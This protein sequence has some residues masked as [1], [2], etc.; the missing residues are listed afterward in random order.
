MKQDNLFDELLDDDGEEKLP[1]DNND[2][3]LYESIYNDENGETKEEP[4]KEPDKEENESELFKFEESE[5]I[6]KILE[7]KGINPHEIL[8]E[9]ENGE[10]VKVNFYELDPEEQ[11]NLLHYNPSQY[12]LD[13]KEVEAI[14]FF[15]ENDISLEDYTEYVKQTAIEEYTKTSSSYDIDSYS[16]EEVY[17]ALLKDQFP[18]LT[19]EEIGMEI[20]KEKTNT[21]LFEKKVSQIREYYKVQADDIKQQEAEESNQKEQLELDETKKQ[22]ANAAVSTEELMGFEIDDNDRREAFKFI[23]DKSVNGKSAF[24]KLLEDP[25]KLFKVALFALKEEE[26]NKTLEQEFKKAYNNNKPPI[27]KSQQASQKA[28]VLIKGS[29]SEKSQANTSMKLSIDDLYSDLLK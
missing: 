9:D 29:P 16:D 4:E 18:T 20:E 24:F 21:A 14:N 19:D 10:E 17:S 15:R 26:I 3:P 2:D 7:S 22:L 1:L 5:S 11:L 28:K 27:I 13:D 8:Y 25:Q 12:D 6:N 23:F